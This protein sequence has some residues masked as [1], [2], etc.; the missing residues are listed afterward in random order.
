MHGLQATWLHGYWVLDT[1]TKCFH[2]WHLSFTLT[3]GL[4]SVGVFCVGIPLAA[5][6]VLCYKVYVNRDKLGNP[7][8]AMDVG[9]LYRS[10]D[11]EYTPNSMNVFHTELQ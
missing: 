7:E 3:V 9:F 8:V 1:S 5:V 2:G 6:L 11:Y 4:I 10:Y